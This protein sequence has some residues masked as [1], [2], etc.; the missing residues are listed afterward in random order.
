M[1]NIVGSKQANS[2]PEKQFKNYISPFWSLNT[3]IESQ[4]TF[5]E[6]QRRKMP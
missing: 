4:R 1:K 5:I 6:S 3:F 2:N